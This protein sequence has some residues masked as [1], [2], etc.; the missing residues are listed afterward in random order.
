M[1]PREANKEIQSATATNT[2][3]ARLVTLKGRNQWLTLKCRRKEVLLASDW[4][5]PSCYEDLP[6]WVDPEGEHSTLRF[7]ARGSRLLLNRSR[8]EGCRTH[9]KKPWGYRTVVGDWMT[10]NP[11]IHQL[12][13]QVEKEGESTLASLELVAEKTI[14][15]SAR[16][17][18][19]IRLGRAPT[20]RVWPT[21][22]TARVDK[23]GH[24]PSTWGDS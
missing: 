20:K 23:P 2:V 13:S 11:R 12:A 8:T 16:Y 19:A 21:E 18:M 15:Q 9:S 4:D 3:K 24:K 22:L 14:C 1:D 5:I 17:E 6:V 10:L 7:L